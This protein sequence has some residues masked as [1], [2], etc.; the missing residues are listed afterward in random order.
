MYGVSTP[1]TFPKK[2]KELET[3]LCGG[4]EQFD[5]VARLGLTEAKPSLPL[6]VVMCFGVS[7]SCGEKSECVWGT[8][9]TLPVFGIYLVQC[10]F[11]A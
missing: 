6:A 8:A 7:F 1:P 9:E 2:P 11:V 4:S 5:G 10:N 3:R